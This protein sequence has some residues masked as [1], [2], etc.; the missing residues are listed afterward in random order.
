MLSIKTLSVEV[1][2]MLQLKK[3][4]KKLLKVINF[5]FFTLFQ[6]LKLTYLLYIGCK[7]IQIVYFVL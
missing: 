5:R 4:I 3:T 6:H 2:F 1:Y 7:I